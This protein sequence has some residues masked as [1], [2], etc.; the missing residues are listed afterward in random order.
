MT[1][2]KVGSRREAQIGWVGLLRSNGSINRA[3]TKAG[4]LPRHA[5]VAEEK[6]C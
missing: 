4:R 2:D 1:T 5:Q 6:N 3:M